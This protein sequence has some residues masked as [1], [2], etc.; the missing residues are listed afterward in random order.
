MNIYEK[1]TKYIVNSYKRFPV[2][3]VN[4]KGSL[5]YDENGR[6]YIDLGSGIGVTAFGIADDRWIDA[7]T[8][9]LKQ[10]Q[11]TSNLYYTK[12]C[13]ELAE[14]LTAKSGMKKVFFCNSGAEANENGIKAVRKYAAINKG[15]DYFTIITLEDSFHGRTITN[16]AAT[17]QE[18]FH[19]LYKPLT[20]GFIHVPPDD[21]RALEEAVKTHPVAGFMIECVQGE[22][23]VRALNKSYVREAAALC[24]ENNLLLFCDEV[25]CGNGRTGYYYAYMYYDVIPDVVTTAKGVG[26]GLPLG[27]CM[28]GE[29]LE[30]IFSFGDVGS[31]Y[32]GN[33]VACAG[34]VS[35]MSRIDD[36]LLKEVREKSAYM[37]RTLRACKGIEDVSGLGLMIGVKTEK[38]TSLVVS[39]LLEKGVLVLSAKGRVRLLPALNIPMD[40]LMEATGKI[41]EVCG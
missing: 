6:R 3:M 1:D 38:P 41:V 26:G 34:G 33:P 5:L 16:L 40:L 22:G 12:P 27:V 13:V 11:H 28:L 4:G 36:S 23:G 19:K 29:R 37:F 30:N 39:K 35:I 7:V 24:R 31:T 8:L 20:P 32:G 18:E 21:I 15:E 14:I 25:Q 17:G 9:Q 10:V 2:C